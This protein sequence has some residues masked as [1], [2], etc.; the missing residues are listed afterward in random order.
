MK[1]KLAP[2]KHCKCSKAETFKIG[3]LWYVR[4]RGVKKTKNGDKPCSRWGLYEFLGLTEKDAI[5][6]WNNKN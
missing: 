1:N 2:C 3:D 6:N 4:C 5:A